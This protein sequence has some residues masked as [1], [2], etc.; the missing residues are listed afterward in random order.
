[1]PGPI[2]GQAAAGCSVR[3]KSPFTEARDAAHP[4]RRRTIPAARI[5]R[6]DRAAR[7]DQFMDAVAPSWRTPARSDLA[8]CIGLRAR[9]WRSSGRLPRISDRTGSAARTAGLSRPALGPILG[10]KHLRTAHYGSL[11]KRGDR[12]ISPRKSRENRHIPIQMHTVLN[13]LA[14]RRL[15]PL[16]HV[17]RAK[18]RAA[19]C[20]TPPAIASARRSSLARA[21]ERGF[22]RPSDD[23]F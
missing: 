4:V 19:T 12:R 8:R 1:M 13:G 16:G 21:V 22:A 6:A 3:A 7:R 11:R 17:S 2:F 10:P 5:G 15:Q 9:S 18:R 20:P 23:R 14:N